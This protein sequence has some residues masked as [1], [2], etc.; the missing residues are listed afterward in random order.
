M[1][2]PSEPSPRRSIQDQDDRDWKIFRSIQL[3]DGVQIHETITTMLATWQRR[4][5]GPPSQLQS[6]LGGRELESP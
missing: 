5:L 3:A 6:V 4:G 1:T 2:P